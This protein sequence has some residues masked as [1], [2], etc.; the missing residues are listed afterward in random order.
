MSRDGEIGRYR[1]TGLKLILKQRPWT[2]YVLVADGFWQR[3]KLRDFLRGVGDI[4]GRMKLVGPFEWEDPRGDANAFCEALR[5]H[6]VESLADL[7]A[8]DPA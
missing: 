3:A 1:S 7:R 5:Q 2:V 6:M 8:P 4:R